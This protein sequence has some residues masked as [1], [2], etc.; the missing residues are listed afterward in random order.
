MTPSELVQRVTAA[1]G[2]AALTL[3]GPA[4]WLGG[5][6]GALGVVA[7]AT[8]AALNFRWL[9]WRTTAALVPGGSA[10]RA[11]AAAMMRL[12]VAL[13]GP[14]VAIATGVV[15]PVGLVVGLTLLPCAVVALGLRASREE[16]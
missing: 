10:A 1:I 16:H 14:A 7:G 4:A 13:A 2:L 11:S 15:H 5:T 3:A 8:L 12:L 6:A 9:A